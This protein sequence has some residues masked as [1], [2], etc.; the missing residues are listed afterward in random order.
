MPISDD[1]LKRIA[2]QLAP[3]VQA[4]SD[5]SAKRLGNFL[6]GAQNSV[7]NP[8]ITGNEWMSKAVSLPQLLAAAGQDSHSVA[9]RVAVKAVSQLPFDTGVDQSAL[10]DA[11][12]SALAEELP[13]AG[14][15][16]VPPAGDEPS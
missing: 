3:V 9:R 8:H 5:S 15:S 10:T 11:L 4:A 13:L 7:F 2:A 1:D 12:A 14:G 16:P 6:Q